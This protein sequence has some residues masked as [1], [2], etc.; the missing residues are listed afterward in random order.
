MSL[1]NYINNIILSTKL[2]YIH[3]YQYSLKFIDFICDTQYFL[4]CIYANYLFHNIDD[5]LYELNIVHQYYNK[6]ILGI[7]MTFIKISNQDEKKINNINKKYNIFNIVN[8]YNSN[9][10]NLL[11]LFIRTLYSYNIYCYDNSNDCIM[12]L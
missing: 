6:P 10:N 2:Q 3:K 12:L 5:F 11:N 1:E 8:I 4:I 9:I 7:Y